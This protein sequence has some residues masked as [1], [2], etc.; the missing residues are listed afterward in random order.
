MQTY[1]IQRTPL[2]VGAAACARA[3]RHAL[4]GLILLCVALPVL[5]SDY[6]AIQELSA[7]ESG[8]GEPNGLFGLSVAVDG[9]L[10]VASTA[11]SAARPAMI[12]TYA[13]N[14]T[15]WIHLADQDITLAGRVQARMS[16]NEGTLTV[17]GYYPD[18][19]A[20]FARIYRHTSAGWD[21][22]LSFTTSEFVS[23]VATTGSIAVVGESSFDGLAGADQGIV[24]ILRRQPDSTWRITSQLPTT[25][26]AKA[27]FGASV[28]IVAGAIV[29]GAPGETVT[30]QSGT[31]QY[32]GAAYVYE[33]TQETWSQVAR[34]V[35]PDVG[36]RSNYHFGNTVAISGADP[37]TP[38]RMLIGNSNVQ[39]YL[40]RSY[41]HI[42][43][44]WTPGFTIPAP[45]PG[46]GDNFGCSLAM[47]GGW[48]VIGACLSSSAGTYAGAILLAKFDSG[49]TNV[50]SLTER[51]D[52]QAGASDGLGS[53]VAIDRAGPTVIVGSY[54]ADLY[55]NDRQGVVLV[56]RSQNGE[57]P[58]L[59]RAMDLG[60]GLTG[61][62]AAVVAVDGD[63]LMLGALNENVGI[64]QQRGAVYVYRRQPDGM[65][66]FESRLLAP[67]GTAGDQFGFHIALKGDVALVSAIGRSHMG[68]EFA[69]AVYA[70]HRNGLAWTLEAQF[71]PPA[72]GYETEFGFGL[73]FDG[74]TAFIGE[75][76]ENATVLER[77]GGGIWTSVQT[78]PHRAWTLQVQGDLAMLGD[79]NVNNTIGEVATYTRSVSGWQPQGVLSG[80]DANQ[81][82]GSEVALDGSLAAV[83][84]NSYASPVQVYQRNGSNWLPQASLLP[85]DATAS[86]TCNHVA[87]HGST[88]ALGCLD[89][90]AGNRGAVYVF[91]KTAGQWNQ[92]QKLTLPNAVDSDV[93]GSSLEWTAQGS[94][95][96]AA[97][98]R[99][100]DF[101]DQGAVYV[102]R[103]DVL[104]QNGF[105]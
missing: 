6:A 67:D 18:L 93:F 45:T 104:F 22:E 71:L 77:S 57:V 14:G 97:F 63:T 89:G 69:G 32:A 38:D 33:L 35:E 46:A 103:G 41:R 23:S 37:S 48:A 64:Q 95:L 81:H 82:F 84:S 98:G 58:V 20:G 96:V 39:G 17:G 105:E 26:Q 4:I 73:A 13:R 54:N 59:T 29:V 53:I 5:A 92:S 87:M 66:A 44:T 102:Y 68:H 3:G 65:Y 42:A 75:F 25:R 47:D 100:L 9:D 91:E 7:I 24:L 61:A 99:D 70:F 55:G 1:P 8:D 31:Y 51:T 50:Q 19:S 79:I 76:N 78:I 80:S 28:A 40:F 85:N 62:R 2:L 30:A 21:R 15:T 34:L 52:P 88:L 94:L 12:R 60:Q 86:T 36:N 49:F 72:P 11:G 90:T 56:G 74:N 27:R 83:T 101:I 16:F 10:A 43:G